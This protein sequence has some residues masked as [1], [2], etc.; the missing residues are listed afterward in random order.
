LLEVSGVNNARRATDL[1]EEKRRMERILRERYAGFSRSD[2]LALPVMR[3]YDNYYKKF[4][5]TYHVQLQ[6]E[7]VVLKGKRLPDVSPLVDA[8]FTAELDTLVLTA[9]HDVACLE[10]PVYI[11]ISRKGETF[12]QMGGVLKDLR[13]GDMLM[14]DRQGIACTILYGQDNRSPITEATSHALYVSYAPEGVG[15]ANVIAQLETVVKNIRLFA[16][17]CCVEQ[18]SVLRA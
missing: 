16:P 12:I 17:G 8:N 18:L 6:L 7:S 3:A 13:A 1:D 2:L 4:D 5:K 11:D 14:R 10:T 15:E 9:G